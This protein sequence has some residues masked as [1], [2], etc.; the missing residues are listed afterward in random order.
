M[1]A[2]SG[3]DGDRPIDERISD[4]TTGGRHLG[5]AKASTKRGPVDSFEFANQIGGMNVAAGFPD[6]KKNAHAR[7]GASSALPIPQKMEKRDP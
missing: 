1:L 3:V 6:G 4:L 7:P 2:P 5:T